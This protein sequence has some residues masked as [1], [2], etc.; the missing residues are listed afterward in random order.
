MPRP[1]AVNIIPLERWARE[2][3]WPKCHSEPLEMQ[4]PLCE[5]HFVYIGERFMSERT[6]LGARYLRAGAPER[7]ER[8]AEVRRREAD[9]AI[10]LEDQ[11]VVYYVRIGDHV[12]IGFSA[13]LRQRL[14]ALRVSPDAVMATEPGGR[15]VEAVRHKEFAAER[16][17]RRE[18]FNPSRRL[19]NHIE[20]IRREHGGPSIKGYPKVS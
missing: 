15:T 20:L 17:G 3:H 12:K 7:E 1:K 6:V 13:N 9:R 16:V 8:Q 11:S 18:D 14:I 2:C 19:L 10:A 4:I 5:R